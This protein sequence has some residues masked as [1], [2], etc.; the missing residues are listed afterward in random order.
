MD[1]YSGESQQAYRKA[2]EMLLASYLNRINEISDLIDTKNR[3]HL[4][5][6]LESVVLQ[7]EKNLQDSVPKNASY[8]PE[9]AAQTRKNTGLSQRRLALELGHP[10]GAIAIAQYETGKH[11]PKNPPES[12]FVKKYLGWLKDN[13]YNPFNLE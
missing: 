12:E 10:S 5:K 3:N 9:I 13:G 1:E 2:Q 8:D 6:S 4:L 7:A 11:K